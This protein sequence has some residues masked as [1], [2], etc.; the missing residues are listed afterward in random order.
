[1]TVRR[2]LASLMFSDA[3]FVTVTAYVPL[4]AHCVLHKHRR[5]NPQQLADHCQG[6]DIYGP[7]PLHP[8]PLPALA[9]L[10][11]WYT[12]MVW[13]T[14]IAAAESSMC[15]NRL[16]LRVSNMQ[17]PACVHNI[18]PL[19]SVPLQNHLWLSMLCCSG[20]LTLLMFALRLAVL[21]LH[22]RR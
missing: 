17:L 15:C 7:P 21:S 4:A 9:V 8:S 3:L 1:M 22:H 16:A 12:S 14:C 11:L 10:P 19:T 2:D 20:Q 5:G 6:N 13:S 18:A